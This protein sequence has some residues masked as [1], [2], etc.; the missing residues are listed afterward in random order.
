MVHVS[1]HLQ[2]D[3]SQIEVLLQQ[4]TKQGRDMAVVEILQNMKDRQAAKV[5]ATI[6]A[7]DPAKAASLTAF[8]KRP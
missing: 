4:L 7:A 1:F 8:L 3:I 6:A 2:T 5:L